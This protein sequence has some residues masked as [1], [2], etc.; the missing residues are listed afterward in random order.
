MG[1]EKNYLD[2]DEYFMTFALVAARKSKDP[3]TQVGACIVGPDN[4]VLGLGYNGFPKGIDDNLIPIAR[5]GE[6]LETKYPYVAHAE[7]NA[8]HNAVADL[9]GSRIYTTLNSCNKC[10]IA[11]IQ[12]GLEEVIFLSDKY[13]NQLE[14]IAGARLLKMAGIRTR[15]YFP[16][17][18]KMDVTFKLIASEIDRASKE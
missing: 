2:W 8:V 7:E 3:S 1:E 12:N 14:F 13:A 18:D 10:A 5:D 15:K 4:K 11:I 6:Y 17:G 16:P 9:K